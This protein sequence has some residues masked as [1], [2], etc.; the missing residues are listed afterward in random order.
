MAGTQLLYGIKTYNRSNFTMWWVFLDC[1]TY[2]AVPRFVER[3]ITHWYS[4][5]NFCSL[6]KD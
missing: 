4:L 2:T 1:I 3:E 5:I 6:N